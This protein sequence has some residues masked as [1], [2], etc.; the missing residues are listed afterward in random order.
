MAL[1]ELSGRLSCAWQGVSRPLGGSSAFLPSALSIA[2]LTNSM[3]A[4]IY[5]ANKSPVFQ[6]LCEALEIK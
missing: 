6:V 2:S 4:Y 1:L 5:P 3:H